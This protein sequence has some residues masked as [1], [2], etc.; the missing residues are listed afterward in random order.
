MAEK[1][2]DLLPDIVRSK[3]CEPAMNMIIWVKA[4][5]DYYY[6]NLKV[7]PKKAALE[8]A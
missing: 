6:V 2:D 4:I 8:V 5:H 3:G 7:K 1:G